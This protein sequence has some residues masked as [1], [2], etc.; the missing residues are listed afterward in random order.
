VAELQLG[1]RSGPRL[2]LDQEVDKVASHKGKIELS[3]LDFVKFGLRLRGE[4]GSIQPINF[5][6]RPYLTP[7]YEAMF[8]R[9]GIEGGRQIEKSTFLVAEGSAFMWLKV[10]TRALYV[11]PTHLQMAVFSKAH[12]DELTSMSVVLSS[13][14][15][16][17]LRRVM[18]KGALNGNRWYLRHAFLHADRIRGIPGVTLVQMDEIQDLRSDSIPVIRETMSHSTEKRERVTGTHK[19]FDGTIEQM[20]K[21]EGVCHEWVIPCDFHS[22]RHWVITGPKSI[23]KKGNICDKCGNLINI[24]HPDAQWAVVSTPN[25]KIANPTK[26]FRINQLMVPWLD[27]GEVLQKVD[28][29]PVGRLKNEVFSMPHSYGTRPIELEVLLDSCVKGRG[30][31]M[32]DIVREANTY[33]AIF[34]GI[35]WG[36]GGD[37]SKT[38]V[39]IGGIK[40]GA[41]DVLY[42]RQIDAGT[43]IFYGDDDVV[44]EH[45]PEYQEIERLINLFK[46]VGIGVD[47]GMGYKRNAHFVRKYGAERILVMQALSSGYGKKFAFDRNLHRYKYNEA[48]VYDVLFGFAH[49]P[50]PLYSFPDALVSKEPFFS[51]ILNVVREG[52]DEGRR[53]SFTKIMNTTDDGWSALVIF[54]LTMLV[55]NPRPDILFLEIEEVDAQDP[56][57]I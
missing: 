34:M 24:Q 47:H 15:P 56:Y 8:P 22:P 55:F 12:I 41:F 18:S 39:V 57:K 40:S 46:P 11:V 31:G 52:G 53:V 37:N 33:R 32:D 49:P 3:P 9:L 45:D 23:G 20:K 4:D 2:L 42:A 6:G 54:S 26:W 19:T 21:M 10:P 28:T 1:K 35:D 44:P 43:R 17:G 51:D 50:N 36:S 29:Y 38:F 7:I 13:M 27:W 16:P 25:K 48:E 30:L 5:S 14:S